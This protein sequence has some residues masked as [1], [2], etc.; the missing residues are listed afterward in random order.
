MTR[1]TTGTI[2]WTDDTDE[3]EATYEI[4]YR[5]TPGEPMVRY[6]PDG[7]GYPGSPDECEILSVRLCERLYPEWREVMEAYFMDLIETEDDLRSRIEVACF[8]DAA[9]RCEVDR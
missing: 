4:A 8:E 6:Y 1:S 5:V 9:A 3:D 7:S 2:H